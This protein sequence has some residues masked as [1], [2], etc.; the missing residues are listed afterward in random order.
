MTKMG[1]RI[2]ID[3][4]ILLYANFTSSPFHS[5]A[6]SKL[7]ELISKNDDLW[8]NRQSFRE[9]W[10]GKS[11][12]MHAAMAF[13]PTEI[14]NDIYQFQQIFQIADETDTITQK[15]LELAFKYHVVGKQIHDT[16]IVAT[17]FVNNI[18]NIL[19]HNISD[20]NRFSSEIN[21]IPLI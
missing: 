19:T 15:L 11:K 7:Q 10:V 13:N 4:N 8:L 14:R 2:F 21:I 3:T 17:M 9:Y 12:A 1:D 5:A 6:L 20:F 18:P 16:N